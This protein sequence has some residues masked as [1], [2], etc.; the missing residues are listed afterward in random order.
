[1]TIAGHP[2]EGSLRT[3]SWAAT[4]RNTRAEAVDMFFSTLLLPVDFAESRDGK[5]R[6][7]VLAGNTSATGTGL[8]QV[9]MSQGSASTGGF[10][11][12]GSAGVSGTGGSGGSSSGAPAPPAPD[13]GCM[14]P[15]P[16]PP[17]GSTTPM[18]QRVA[19][20]RR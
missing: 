16:Q 13:Q 20:P 1:M 6:A 15:Q 9:H 4:R 17:P 7:I 5:R 19:S 3:G 8:P 14:F 11:G 12:S 18:P 2:S 10:G